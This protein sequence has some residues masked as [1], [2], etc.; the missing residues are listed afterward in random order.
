MSEYLVVNA[1]QFRFVGE[2]LQT[3][4]EGSRGGRVA[5]SSDHSVSA[6]T[7]TRVDVTLKGI[8]PTRMASTRSTTLRGIF[9]QTVMIFLRSDGRSH[10]S[11]IANRLYLTLIT[12]LSNDICF[13]LA[14]ARGHIALFVD[15]TVRMTIAR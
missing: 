4:T 15:N 2:K 13:A 8:G 11:G 6:W 7:L 3:R 5:L 1:R 9:M 10:R 14:H 12:A